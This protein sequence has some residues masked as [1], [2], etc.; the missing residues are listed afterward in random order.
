MTFWWWIEP[1]GMTGLFGLLL[2]GG[3]CILFYESNNKVLEVICV[4]LVLPLVV[5]TLSIL[6][7]A[8]CYV[9]WFIWHPYF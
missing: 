2:A 4:L 6:V 5:A 8:L 1:L 3:L 9:F 7:W